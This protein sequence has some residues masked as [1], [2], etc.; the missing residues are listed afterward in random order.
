M[1]RRN[2]Y[3]QMRERRTLLARKAQAVLISE[4]VSDNDELA[5]NA[6]KHLIRT[7]QRNRLAVPMNVRRMICKG[8]T[9]ILRPGVNQ[10]VRVRAGMVV[11]TCLSCGRTLRIGGG[12][13]FHRRS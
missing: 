1:G 2:R 6:A 10:R 4:I 13:K 11:R 9:K 12:P 3:R 8:C 7:S 5:E